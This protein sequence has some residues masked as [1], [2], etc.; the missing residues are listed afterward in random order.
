M[1]CPEQNFL[2]LARPRKSQ[3]A[4][5]ESEAGFDDSLCKEAAT[6]RSSLLCLTASRDINK[7]NI[8]NYFLKKGISYK[9]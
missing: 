6:Y 2:A 5:N 4:L 7:R 9:S 8:F 1:A 3:H